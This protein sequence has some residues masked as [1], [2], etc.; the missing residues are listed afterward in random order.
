VSC[1]A[2]ASRLPWRGLCSA[3]PRHAF[4]YALS[5]QKVLESSSAWWSPVA[6]LAVG[7]GTAHCVGV[8]PQYV[9]TRI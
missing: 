6:L 4:S 5:R 7:D 3:H 1:V 2:V 8:S 9:K